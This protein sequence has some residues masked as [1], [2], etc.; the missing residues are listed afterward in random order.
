MLNYANLY[1]T[2]T[3]IILLFCTILAGFLVGKHLER[4]Q[5]NR[6]QFFVD[7]KKYIVL[8]KSN[9]KTKR[10]EL[11]TFNAQ[12]S[13]SCSSVFGKFLLEQAP[14]PFLTKNQNQIV[15]A[16]FN[17]LSATTSSELLSNLDF[18]EQQIN[19]EFNSVASDYQSRH[20]FVKL[21]ILC[22][23]VVGILLL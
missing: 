9:V 18:Y 20:A 17:S 2:M 8:L 3:N 4:R 7:L 15:L 6:W 11:Q 22:G 13:Q 1:T 19:L 23:V 12:F 5:V 16:F 14:L 10:I 21:S